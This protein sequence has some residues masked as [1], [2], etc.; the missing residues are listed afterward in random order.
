MMQA[1][2]HRSLHGRY[3]LRLL[4]SEARP[5]TNHRGGSA[6][7]QFHRAHC[8]PRSRGRGEPWTM[9]APT[10]HYAMKSVAAGLCGMSSSAVITIIPRTDDILDSCTH[11]NAAWKKAEN[12]SS[13]LCMDAQSI[14]SIDLS[15]AG[16]D[17]FSP[18]LLS[19]FVI[20]SFTCRSWS[21]SGRSL[22]TF[23][24]GLLSLFVARTSYVGSP[25]TR[26]DF[27]RDSLGELLL[28]ATI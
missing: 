21:P 28:A 5:T 14:A 8:L 27:R 26:R 12:T 3:V 11:R 17:G 7:K 2:L 1:V 16:C 24:L 6:L 9:V 4:N 15:M 20:S 22:H 10:K 23:S 19:I 25:E 18:I 13:F